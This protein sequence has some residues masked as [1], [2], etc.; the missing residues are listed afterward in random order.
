MSAIRSATSA[1]SRMSCVTKTAVFVTHDMREAGIVADRI[2]LVDAGRLVAMGTLAELRAA[3]D[4][5]VRAFL[6]A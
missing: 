3:A 5:T 1:A 6:E 4:P 2:A